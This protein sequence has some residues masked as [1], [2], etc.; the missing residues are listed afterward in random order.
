MY[1]DDPCPHPSWLVMFKVHITSNKLMK[2]WEINEQPL[3]I[4]TILNTI[5]AFWFLI[6][7]LED[8]Y[9]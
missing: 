9:D 1:V 8:K 6:A 7:P 2:Y 5:N 4:S 3:T